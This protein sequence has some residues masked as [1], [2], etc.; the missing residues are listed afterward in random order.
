MTV[1]QFRPSPRIV[2]E[3]H[4]DL[5]AIDQHPPLPEFRGNNNSGDTILNSRTLARRP[6]VIFDSA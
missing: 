3:P 2:E 4:L 1:H 5:A 6:A